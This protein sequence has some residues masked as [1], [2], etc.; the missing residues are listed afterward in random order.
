MV[1]S[2]TEEDKQT[3]KRNFEAYCEVQDRK[4]ELAEENKMLIGDTA[5][6]LDVKKPVVSKLFA[7]LKK[8]MENG[9]DEGDEVSQIIELIFRD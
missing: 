8:R 1:P 5:F 3:V 4:K 7:T 2:I 6:I 9:G